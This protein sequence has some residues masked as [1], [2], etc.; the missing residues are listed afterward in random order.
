MLCGRGPPCHRRGRLPLGHP[1]PAP[2]RVRPAGQLRGPAASGRC[3]EQLGYQIEGP[4]WRGIYLGAALELREGVQPP[5]FETASPDTILAMP[6][7]ILFDFVAVHLNG[8]AAAGADLRI[9]LEFTD[10][11]QTWTMWIKNGVLHAR[12]ARSSAAQ[13][14]ISGP[15]AELVTTLLQPGTA[16]ELAK[17]ERI[18]LTGDPTALTELAGLLDQFAPTFEVITP[19]RRT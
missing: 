5:P 12:R 9:D 17:E 14:T 10:H 16:E 13:L 3:Y 1:D 8:P 7:G 2:P 11:G 18:T 15:K 6:V 4:Q 19:C